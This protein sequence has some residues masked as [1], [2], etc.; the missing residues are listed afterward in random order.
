M[1]GDAQYLLIHGLGWGL[2]IH[3][4]SVLGDS[5]TLLGSKTTEHMLPSV[6]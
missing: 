1:P 5:D 6:V 4:L 2:G 3:T